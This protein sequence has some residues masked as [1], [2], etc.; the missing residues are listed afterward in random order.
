MDDTSKLK[1]Q[2]ENLN[3]V[4]QELSEKLKTAESALNTKLESTKAEIENKLESD[5]NAFIE[6][7]AEVEAK[8]VSMETTLTSIEEWIEDPDIEVGEFRE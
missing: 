1:E 3:R 4:V 5:K 7:L 6:G 8:R 2:L